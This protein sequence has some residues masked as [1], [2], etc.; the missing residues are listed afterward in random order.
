MNTRPNPPAALSA[1]SRRQLGELHM[2]LLRLHKVLLDDERAVYE[3]EHGRI[4]GT[5]MLDLVINDPQFAWLRR[6]S[7]LIVEVDEITESELPGAEDEAKAVLTHIRSLLVPGQSGNEFQKKYD[8]ALQRQPD[9]VL[10]HGQVISIL[11]HG[12]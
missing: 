2:A 4:G 6:I 8:D 3:R 11:S 12:E 1:A 7:E 10:I 5:K 9:A